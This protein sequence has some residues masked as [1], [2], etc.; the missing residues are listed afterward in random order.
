MTKFQWKQL[1]K[2]NISKSIIMQGLWFLR[3][4]R[5]L[6]LINID[7]KFREDSL[8]GFEV[9]ARRGLFDGQSSKGNNS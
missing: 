7:M 4:A 2:Y 1:K 8:N 5:R 3:A 9:L 6:M